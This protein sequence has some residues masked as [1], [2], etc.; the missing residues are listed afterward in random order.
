MSSRRSDL[1]RC[2]PDEARPLSRP[3]WVFEFKA[4]VKR[5]RRLAT[6][7]FFLTDLAYLDNRERARFLRALAPGS[8]RLNLGA[9]FRASPEGFVGVDRADY[10][11]IG[12]RADLGRLPLPDGSVDGILCEMVLEHVP[13]AR[14]AIRE[15]LRV[16]RPGG[17]LYVAVPF[18]WPYHASPDDYWRWTTTGVEREFSAFETVGT[19]VAGGPT[20]TLMN[21]LHEWLALV[22][23]F[24]VDALYRVFYLALLPFMLPPKLL[25]LVLSRYRHAGKIGALLYFHGVKPGSSPAPP[26]LAPPPPR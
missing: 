3:D 5:N 24:N 4:R 19:G 15:F 6:A 1:L 23:S 8:R 9:G 21:V 2:A 25:D 7:I 13:D 11:G 14:G 17:R 18:L 22:L 26:P 20:T 12:L 16:L 10:P